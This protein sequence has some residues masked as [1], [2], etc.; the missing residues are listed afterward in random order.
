MIGRVTYMTHSGLPQALVPFFTLH[1]SAI[2]A[3]GCAGLHSPQRMGEYQNCRRL[4]PESCL[5]VTC[6]EEQ[7]DLGQ[8]QQ[9][10]TSREW[11]IIFHYVNLTTNSMDRSLS[12][13]QELVIDREDWH[14]AIHGIAKSWTRLSD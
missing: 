4:A 1:L 13:L 2:L 7:L 8:G 3:T 10:G 12:E 11:E 9:Q 6:P 5:E 14:V